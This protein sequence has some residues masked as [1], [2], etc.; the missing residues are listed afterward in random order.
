MLW[1]RLKGPKGASEGRVEAGRGGRELDRSSSHVAP[2]ASDAS[3]L[4]E[5]AVGL[6][7]APE[8]AGQG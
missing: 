5:S 4:S 8:E 6:T 7:Q 2:H 1:M 3:L